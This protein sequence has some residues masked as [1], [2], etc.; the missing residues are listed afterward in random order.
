MFFNRRWIFGLSGLKAGNMVMLDLCA[1][2][3][4]WRPGWTSNVD[5]VDT[6]YELWMIN[7]K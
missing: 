7:D 3:A 4:D 5:S 2:D 1:F 6:R